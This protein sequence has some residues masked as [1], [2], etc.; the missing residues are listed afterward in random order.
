MI[1]FAYFKDK[2]KNRLYLIIPKRLVR[3]AT[4]RNKIRRQ[5]KYILRTEFNNENIFGAIRLLKS[6][7]PTFLE[8]KKE[9]VRIINQYQKLL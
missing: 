3:F 1:E 7:N 8:I 4:K 9:I 2:P 6:E 5:I